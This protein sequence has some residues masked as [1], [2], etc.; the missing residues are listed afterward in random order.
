MTP[1]K[2]SGTIESAYG[3]TL[4]S[5]VKFEG[6]YDKYANYEEAVAAQDLPSRDEQLALINNKRKAN[7]RQ[8][9][10]QAALDAA[11]ISKPT[12]D[13]PQV[14]L[15]T[16]IKALVASGKDEATATQIAEATLGVKLNVAA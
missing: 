1:E 5:A 6:T 3:S 2:F 7:A 8:K 16:I 11:G 14:Q 10:M 9:A 15:K 13:D 4:P 12:L